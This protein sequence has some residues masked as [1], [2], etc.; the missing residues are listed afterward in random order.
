MANGLLTGG[1]N[2]G[3]DSSTTHAAVSE[4]DIIVRDKE[5][6]QDVANLSRDVEHASQ[7]LS[8]IFDKEKEQQRLQQSQLI[9]EIGNQVADIAR[10]EGQINAINAGKAELAKKKINEPEKGASKEAWRNIMLSWPR[11]KAIRRAATMGH[12]QQRP[13][14]DSGGNRRRAGAGGQ[15]PEGGAGRR[16]R[17]VCRGGY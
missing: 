13:A 14:G 16:R 1:N 3:H 2:E 5:Q 9:G 6:Q 15:R 4:G 17:A 11:P 8:P 10:T 12:R 7:T